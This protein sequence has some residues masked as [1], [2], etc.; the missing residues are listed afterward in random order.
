MISKVQ[1]RLAAAI[2]VAVNAVPEDAVEK[3]PEGVF[4]AAAAMVLEKLEEDGIQIEETHSE[5]EAAKKIFDI[6]GNWL[7]VDPTRSYFTRT[8]DSGKL[9]ITLNTT[10]H[11]HTERFYGET[12]QDVHAQAAQTV[13]LQ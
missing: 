7:A 3:D 11:Q 8:T 12:L 2:R 13:A 4:L 1:K 6:I 10:E 5:A 9:E